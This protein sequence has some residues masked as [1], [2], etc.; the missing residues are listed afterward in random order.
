ME[1]RFFF[2][3]PAP[4]FVAVA[5]EIAA[6][7]EAAR[8]ALLAEKGEALERCF[9]GAA[10]ACLVVGS[11]D[12]LGRMI[13]AAR[14]AEAA[15]EAVLQMAWLRAIALEPALFEWEGPVPQLQEAFLA[16]KLEPKEGRL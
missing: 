7:P 14:V 11:I 3:Q 8:P 5:A 2:F 4:L 13:P 10:A 9:A 6:A 1:K 16:V 15:V 12:H